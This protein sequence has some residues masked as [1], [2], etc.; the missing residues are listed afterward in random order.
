M[1]L[2][3]NSEHGSARGA[4]LIRSAA[5]AIVPACL[6]FTQT[7]RTEALLCLPF[8]LLCHPSLV[9]TLTGLCAAI[10]GSIAVTHVRSLGMAAMPG[11]LHNA[12]FGGVRSGDVILIATALALAVFA[13]R[14]KLLAKPPSDPV[15]AILLPGFARPIRLIIASTWPMLPIVALP[16]GFISI[17]AALVWG[18]GLVLLHRALWTEYG[19][20]YPEAIAPGVSS[21]TGIA[22]LRELGLIAIITIA[23]LLP[24]ANKPFHI[25]DPAYLWTAQQ[26]TAAP[27]DFYGFD[28]YM[29]GVR[30]PMHM[31]MQNPPLLSYFLAGV[32]KISGWNE[33]PMH[34]LIFAFTL[35]AILGSYLLAQRFC[36]NAWAVALAVLSA[37]GFYVSASTIMTDIPML[38]F[39]V[40]AAHF[41]LVGYDKANHGFML[42]A[43]VLIALAALT[44]YFGMTLIPLLFVY[45]VMQSGGLRA[46]QLYLLIPVAALTAYELWTR[47]FYGRG[48]LLGA[49]DYVR[50]VQHMAPEGLAP[51]WLVGAMFAGG[52]LGTIALIGMTCA[53][54]RTIAALTVGLLLTTVAAAGVLF[55]VRP[56]VDAIEK[57]SIPNLWLGALFAALSVSIIALAAVDFFRNPGPDSLLLGMWLGGSILFCVAANWSVTVRALLPAVVPTA[58]IMVR[59]LEASLGNA[60]VR[61][62]AWRMFLAAGCAMAIS[63]L[64]AR[65]D[66][67]LAR[68]DRAMARAISNIHM[69]TGTLWFDGRWGLEYYLR[70]Y[71][72][73]TLI[74]AEVQAGDRVALPE[75]ADVEKLLHGHEYLLFDEVQISRQGH[76][77][78]MFAGAGFYSSMFGPLPVA[79][80]D[81]PVDR[82]RLY[83]VIR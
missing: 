64:F 25:D 14:G 49:G 83:D 6:W 82:Y 4:V 29:N 39:Y 45:S 3:S 43:S 60:R 2:S 66:T 18:V 55:L 71:G 42:S 44:K 28:V 52:S 80:G 40:W 20:V 79:I 13:I 62:N 81:A 30:I 58:I 65:G 73:S 75:R 61:K 11:V 12:Y 22:R 31:E 76:Y 1:A 32:A 17:A 7:N 24:F 27:F 59:Q 19:R 37:P 67:A 72:G 77:Q 68:Y 10:A 15:A 26:I 69:D 53:R 23:V 70:T 9:A 8:L 38:A 16:F 57:L 56:N 63:T 5:I 34:A 36:T 46:R 50:D 78:T 21:P 47:D 74:S 51:A 48:L 54:A 35:A 33:E 41:W